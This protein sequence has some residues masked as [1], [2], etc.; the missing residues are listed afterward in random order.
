MFWLKDKSLTDLDNLPEPDDLA[1]E[2]IEL[3]L[4]DSEGELRRVIVDDVQAHPIFK[5]KRSAKAMLEANADAD[6]MLART[7]RE[8]VNTW[9]Y[10]PLMLGEGPTPFC[11]EMGVSYRVR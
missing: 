5:G 2:I 6:P 9:R 11:H 7:L 1:E 8:A 3:G 10:R 4:A